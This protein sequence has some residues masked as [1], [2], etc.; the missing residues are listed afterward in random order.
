MPRFTAA[1]AR[2]MAALSVAARKAA[3]AKRTLS[4]ATIPLSAAAPADTDPG[5]SVACV[6]ARLATLDGM[7]AK[8]KSDREWDNLTRAFDRLFRVWCVLSNTPGPGN[9]KPGPVKP[10]RPTWRDLEPRLPVEPLPG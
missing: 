2:E 5:V 6:R 3:E 7:M 10:A 8:A 9:R 1:T 4:P